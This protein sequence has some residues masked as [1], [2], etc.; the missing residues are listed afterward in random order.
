VHRGHYFLPILSGSGCI[1]MLVCRL[2]ST[3]SRGQRT[4][5]WTRLTDYGARLTAL[6]RT[7]E[8]VALIGATNGVGRTLTLSY[9]EPSSAVAVDADGTP[10]SFSVIY[11]DLMTGNIVPNLVRKARLS[12]RMVGPPETKLHMAFGDT[13][14]AAE[15]DEFDWDEAEWADDGGAFTD[16]EGEAPPDPEALNPHKWRV[17]RK[18]RF[19]RVRIYL[20]GPASTVSL[21]S[22]ELFTRSSGRL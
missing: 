12:Y 20:T 17:R 2:D 8:D 14:Y 4:F 11:R 5:P 16:L 6:A 22:L 1:D 21:R 9:F 10:H 7:D 18:V 3:N 19:A 15:W 13:S